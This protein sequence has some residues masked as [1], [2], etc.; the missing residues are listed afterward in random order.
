M[1]FILPYIASLRIS[2]HSLPEYHLTSL[3]KITFCFRVP[4]V[5]YGKSQQIHPQNSGDNGSER[6]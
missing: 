1:V 3:F 5:L 2:T 4:S 6:C